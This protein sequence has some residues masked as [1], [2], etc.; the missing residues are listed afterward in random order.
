MLAD[1]LPRLSELELFDAV[2]GH[3]SPYMQR[4][5]LYANVRTT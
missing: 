1:L 5:I 4:S 3:F 2:S